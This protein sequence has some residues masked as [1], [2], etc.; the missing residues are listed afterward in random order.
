LTAA[1]VSGPRRG[2]EHGLAFGGFGLRA[3]AGF[4]QGLEDLDASVL[5][6]QRDR[7]D[8]VAIGRFAL[9]PLRSS[10][11][12]RSMSLART[13]QCSAVVP[14]A[15]AAFASARPRNSSRT[16]SRSPRFTASTSGLVD[17]RASCNAEA[18]DEDHE[19]E[20]IRAHK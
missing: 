19:P 13:A 7:R 6:G 16:A 15:V 10:V 11:L 20:A 1:G 5:R 18:K 17:W 4:Q 8:A 2:E 12:T 9:A 3:R 14:S